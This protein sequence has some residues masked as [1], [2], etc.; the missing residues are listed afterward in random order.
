MSGNIE[1]VLL[2]GMESGWNNGNDELV[3]SSSQNDFKDDAFSAYKSGNYEKASE[4]FSTLSHQTE[5]KYAL[6]YNAMSLMMT[7]QIEQATF[8]LTDT[9]WS[10]EYNEKSD[11]YLALC[12]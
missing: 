8:I 7:D 1:V 11:W 10:V 2:P 4:L 9:E 12:Y 3:R 5:E 6:F